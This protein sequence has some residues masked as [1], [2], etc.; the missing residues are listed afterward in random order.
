MP[1]PSCRRC[2]RCR[3]RSREVSVIE[4][5]LQRRRSTCAPR[6]SMPSAVAPLT[7]TDLPLPPVPAPKQVAFGLVLTEP[8]SPAPNDLF[9]EDLAAACRPR[10]D[11]RT[12]PLATPPWRPARAR[13]REPARTRRPAGMERVL[14]FKP[15][16]PRGLSWLAG[17][18][19]P[20]F[21]GW[22]AAPSR[23]IGVL[24]SGRR[25]GARDFLDPVT[26]AGP[27]RLLTGLPLTTDRIYA[28]ESIPPRCP[29]R[30]PWRFPD[31]GTPRLPFGTSPVVKKS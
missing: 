10:A 5:R 29:V 3:D 17:D 12:A 16:F 2:R 11:R 30:P 4:Q 9:G 22:S 20:G 19:S 21:R 28:G 13:A 1:L 14:A 24:P 15:P 18:R 31:R 23:G 27:R 25:R 7:V 26:V 6:I 8:R